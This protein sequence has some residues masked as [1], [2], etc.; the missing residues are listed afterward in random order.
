MGQIYWP[1]ILAQNNFKAQY[2]AVDRCF[3]TRKKEDKDLPATRQTEADRSVQR[4][5]TRANPSDHTSNPKNVL[6]RGHF[7]AA[8]HARSAAAA[9]LGAG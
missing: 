6:A 1:N 4:Q 7:Q 8:P 3:Q 5:V 2:T 9:E